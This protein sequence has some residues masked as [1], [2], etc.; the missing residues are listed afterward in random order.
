MTILIYTSGKHQKVKEIPEVKWLTEWQR[1]IQTQASRL[2]ALLVHK[3]PTE[4]EER[5]KKQAGHSKWERG[6]FNMEDN[7][8][9]KLVLGATRQEDLHT[10]LP[11]LKSVERGLNGVQSCTI[12]MFSRTH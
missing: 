2:S 11:N 6:R 5:L 9:T 7:L 8:P 10:C 3:L 12:Q 1:Q 4:N